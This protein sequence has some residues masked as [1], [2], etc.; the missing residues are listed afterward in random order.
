MGGLYNRLQDEVEARSGGR[1]LSPVDL[2]DMPEALATVI[3]QI[4]RNNGMKLDDIATLLEQSSGDAKAT[5]DDLAA[6]GYVRKTE[7][8]NQLWYKAHFG[9]KQEKK[10]YTGIWSLLDSLMEDEQR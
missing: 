8:K 3:N 4:V 2:L 1:G 9:R 10:S 7:V 5:L 6:K